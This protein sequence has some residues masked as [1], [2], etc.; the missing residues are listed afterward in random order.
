MGPDAKKQKLEGVDHLQN[1][2]PVT[3]FLAWCEKVGLE[4]NP[5]VYISTEGTVSQ[6]GMLA[7]EDIADGEL[8]FTVPRSAIL[9]Q[10]TTRIQEL[11]EKEQESLQSTSGWVPLLISLLYEATDSSSLWAPYFGLWPELDPPDM[12]MF[13]SEEEQTKLLQGTGVLEA[14]RNDLKNIEEEYNSIVLPFITRNPEKFCPMKHTLDLYKRLVAFVMAYSFQEPL[15][16]ND[17]EDEDE[18]DILPPMMVP[19]ADLLNHVAHH[20][21]H[22]EFTPECLRMVTTKS[23]H[24]GQELFNTYGEMANWQ[25]LHMYGFAEPHPQNSN[26]TADIQMVTMREAALQAAQTEDDRLEMQKRW[27]FLCHIEMVGE[28]GA[29][30]FGLEEVMTE[31]ELKVS[32]KVLC[33][34]KEEFAEYKENDG[35][36]EDEG[37]DEQTLMIQEISHLPTPWRK[38]LHLSA[39]LTLKNYSTELS[40]DEALVNNIT[41]YAKLS[42]REQRSLQVKYGQKRILHQLLELTKS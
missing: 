24:A 5:K 9:S 22:L 42:S 39:K 11:L 4:L 7:R 26:E 32:L 40:M 23:V 15:E 12:P 28:E 33:M 41:A 13:W 25:L 37:D 35:W 38:L 31:E 2:F 10:N 8:L 17:E 34:S 27:D 16:E 29:F 30:V 1:G 21:A 20:N 18:K 14:I 36:E 6:Y 3:R 19:V